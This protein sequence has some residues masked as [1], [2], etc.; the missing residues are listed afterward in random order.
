MILEN[1]GN[2]QS[3]QGIHSL[4]FSVSNNPLIP[5]SD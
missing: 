3:Q 5:M 2:L 4:S 1:V